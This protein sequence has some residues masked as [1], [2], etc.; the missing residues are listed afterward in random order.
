MWTLS[1]FADE[2]SPDPRMQCE[3]LRGLDISWLEMRSAWN[4]RAPALTDA[5]VT[6]LRAVFEDH[7]IRVSSIGSPIGKIGVTDS[8]AAHLEEFDRTV[9]VAERLAA[10]Y[11][12]LFSFYTD[13]PD[14][15]REEVLLRM[16]ALTDRVRGRDV[17]LLHEN[18]KGIYGCTPA[19]C[20]DIVEAI[21]SEQ[22]RL[23]WDPA[24]FVQCG[25]RP[26]TDGYALLRPYLAYVQVKDARLGD[27]EVQVAGAGDGEWPETIRALRDDGFEGF[28]SMEPHLE[29]VGQLGG[30]SGPRLFST[31]TEAFTELLRAA[32]VQ[33]R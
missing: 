10:P 9:A 19:R 2:I 23:A 4:V 5:Q 28:F 20:R 32:G 31:A 15:D 29:S 14:R 13:H 27:G 17:T 24:N 26:F 22:L 1:G 33:Y 6:T 30:F 3:V 25:V 12:R 7:E 11:I 16:R 18:E 8:F 21:G